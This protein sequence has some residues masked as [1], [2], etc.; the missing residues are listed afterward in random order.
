MRDKK[1]KSDI[2]VEL[3]KYSKEALIN[4]FINNNLFGAENLLRNVKYEEFK[5]IQKKQDELMKEMNKLNPVKDYIK[6]K[7]LWNSYERYS[8]QA[9]KLLDL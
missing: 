1:S 9:D 2:E 5:I 7:K 6:Y 4:A 3:N 8:K